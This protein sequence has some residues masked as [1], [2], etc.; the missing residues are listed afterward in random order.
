MKETYFKAGSLIFSKGDP[1]ENFYV[2]AQGR[3]EVFDPDTS[4]TVATIQ[5][6]GT[7][8]EQ[9]A[10][11]YGPRSLSARA[12]S[13]A[14][15]IEHPAAELRDLLVQESGPVRHALEMLLLQLEMLNDFRGQ[16]SKAQL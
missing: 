2:L 4:Y 3:V 11:G 16:G 14:H 7:F 15:C 12:V 6:G 9:S 10:L 13:D 5:D 8:G 1:A